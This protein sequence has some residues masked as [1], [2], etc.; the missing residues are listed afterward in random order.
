[1]GPIAMIDLSI[2]LLYTTARPHLIEEVVQ[3]WM[4]RSVDLVEM[5]VVTDDYV[6]R[7]VVRP[8]IRFVVNSGRRD[9]VTGWNLAARHARNNIFIQVSDDLYPPSD[10]HATIRRVVLKV[11]NA[12]QDVVL[13]LLDERRFADAV[14]HPIMTRAAYETASYL[15]PP[16]F[17]S[18]YC[19]YWFCE[20]HKKNS[21]YHASTRVFWHHRHHVTH[22]V[23]IDDVARVHESK[24]R[25]LEGKKTLQRY[26]ERAQVVHGAPV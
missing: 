8:N 4:D 10:W 24:S 15:Y 19:D 7:A 22:A 20:F 1:M 6:D 25:F 11:G 5:I 9:C 3:R 12:R 26:R 13:N 16:D 18:M 17:R 21:N 23:T 2:S 14:F